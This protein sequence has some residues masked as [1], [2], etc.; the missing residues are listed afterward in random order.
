MS[1]TIFRVF[2][3]F[4]HVFHISHPQKQKPVEG[5]RATLEL[6]GRSVERILLRL[7]FFE[8]YGFAVLV[9]F[10]GVY[11]RLGDRLQT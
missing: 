4:S 11:L 10:P 6:F 8:P 7:H 2:R 9:I 5:I 1:V 3:W